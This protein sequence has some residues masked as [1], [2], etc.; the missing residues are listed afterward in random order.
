MQ[1]YVLKRL[2]STDRITAA[3]RLFRFYEQN[4]SHR[5]ALRSVRDIIDVIRTG[6]CF[7]IE[8]ASGAICGAT[9]NFHPHKLHLIE[10]GMTNVQIPGFGLQKVF[11]S[12]DV[13]P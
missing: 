11:L 1:K 5:N 10:S 8:T 13:T 3:E 6:E 2:D 7:T 4:W 12:A 9:A